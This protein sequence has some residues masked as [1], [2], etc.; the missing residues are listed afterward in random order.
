MNSTTL[1][2]VRRESRAVKALKGCFPTAAAPSLPPAVDE[3]D[4]LQD[5]PVLPTLEQSGS[6]TVA[7]R[8]ATSDSS[9]SAITHLSNADLRRALDPS[10]AL[11]LAAVRAPTEKQFLS[12]ERRGL[13]GQC[14]Y[15]IGYSYFSGI[16]VGGTFGFLRGFHASPNMHPRVVLNSVLNGSGKFGA[17]AGNAMGVLS[18]IYTG[19]CGCQRAARGDAPSSPGVKLREC[20]RC[21]P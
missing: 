3:T 18:L 13:W 20:L 11:D 2:V 16:L 4:E 9:P 10:A 7:R 21:G 15:N 5:L 1:S 12:Y 6:R 19:A 14:A 8:D 17:R